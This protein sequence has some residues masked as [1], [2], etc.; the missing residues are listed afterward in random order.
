LK[1]HEAPAVNEDDARFSP[2]QF[3]EAMSHVAGAVHVITTSDGRRRAGFTA[4]AVTAVSDHPPTILV[5]ANAGS[6][7]TDALIANGNFAVN[8]LAFDDESIAEIF[9]GRTELSG[10][11]RFRDH[12]WE[13]LVTGAPILP[14]SL[15]SLDCRVLRADLVGTHYVLI[16]EVLASREGRA[17]RALVYHER[18]FHAL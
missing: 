9:A 11:A 16:G 3:R 18:V 8:T 4:T 1:P 2:E 5:C 13:K 17:R 7:S 15:V 10:D 14:T 12:A 6:A